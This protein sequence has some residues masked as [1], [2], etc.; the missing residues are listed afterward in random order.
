VEDADLLQLPEAL[1]EHVRADVGDPGAKVREPL[2]ADHQLSDDQ[3]SPPLPDQI[4]GVG[5]SASVLVWANP[6]HVPISIYR[7]IL[8]Y[9]WL[10]VF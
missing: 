5:R 6:S 7:F 1:T 2:R 3:Q 10:V 8:I 4:E 9:N